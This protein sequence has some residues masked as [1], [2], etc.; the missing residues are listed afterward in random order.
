MLACQLVAAVHAL[1][2]HLVPPPV[3][4]FVVVA[5]VLQP[6]TEDRPP[7]GDITTATDLMVQLAEL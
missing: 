6:G 5:A 4:A 3:P 2:L 1:W 7:T